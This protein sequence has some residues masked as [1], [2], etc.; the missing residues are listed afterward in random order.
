M[1][2][3]EF[4][5][6]REEQGPPFRRRALFPQHWV[7]AVPGGHTVLVG[8]DV[9]ATLRGWAHHALP[10]ETGGMLVGRVLED[11]DGAY[12]LVQAAV[13]AP[14]EAGGHGELRLSADLTQRL[15]EE[16]ARAHPTCDPVGWW[17]SHPGPS[18]YSGTD[19]QNQ[20]TWTDERHVGILVFARSDRNWGRVYVGPASIP[21]QEM[22]RGG[23]AAAPQQ[24]PRQ[25]PPQ[26]ANRRA[27]SRPRISR[28]AAAL[29]L[30]LVLVLVAI[31]FGFRHLANTINNRIPADGRPRLTFA[32]P[33]SPDSTAYRCSVRTD[34][35]DDV[36]WQINGHFVPG[37][38]V[39]VIR[40]AAGSAVPVELWLDD[41]G[42]RYRVE[43]FTLDGPPPEAAPPENPA[44]RTPGR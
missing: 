22:S 13:A 15:K 9:L 37:T 24:A 29:L 16:G 6:L 25:P 14:P 40:P 42:R 20:S 7:F 12:T 35:P 2:G 38:T 1:S 5:I 39:T 33:L 21:A 27:L 36:L 43:S 34:S 26:P 41:D 19:R 18:A 30:A 28:S 3:V 8:P 17:H 10:R 32:C 31:A 44:P 23:G 4:E 11:A